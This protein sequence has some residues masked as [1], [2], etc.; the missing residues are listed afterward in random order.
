[1]FTGII[2]ASATLRGIN[3]TNNGYILSISRPASFSDLREG[4]S[5]ACNGICLTVLSFDDS[6]FTCQI[7]NETRMK[8][9]AKDWQIGDSINLERALRVG[10]RMDGHWVQGHIDKVLPL[11]RIQTMG[12]TIYLWF[13]YPPEDQNLLVPQ[14]SI[15]LNGVSLTLAKLDNQSFA[16][17]IIN[18]TMQNTNLPLLKPGSPVN[19]EYD[20]LG[21]YLNRS[22][23]KSKISKE[24]LYENGF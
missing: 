6:R 14:G 17:A 13:K 19:I 3:S 22:G 10:D 8:T 9:N 12:A 4:A 21:K 20:V 15:S 2:E 16:V 7:M 18:H 5:I 23:N 24:W 1:M 11:N